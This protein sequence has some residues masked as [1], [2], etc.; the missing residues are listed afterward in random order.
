[1][2]TIATEIG[3]MNQLGK[4]LCT[5]YIKYFMDFVLYINICIYIL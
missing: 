5:H 4:L 1:M 2:G 3:N